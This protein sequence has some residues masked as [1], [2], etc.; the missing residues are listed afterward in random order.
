ML[1]VWDEDDLGNDTK[2][3]QAVRQQKPKRIL[4]Q[5]SRKEDVS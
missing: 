1:R 3:D 4:S 2:N 5:Q